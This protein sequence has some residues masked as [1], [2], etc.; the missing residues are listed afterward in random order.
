MSS[1]TDRIF[2]YLKL[3]ARILLIISSLLLL[4][5]ILLL[6]V[7]EEECFNV[8]SGVGDIM[9]P[10]IVASIYSVAYSLLVIL[11]SLLYYA[12]GRQG[13]WPLLKKEILLLVLTGILI[14]VFYFANRY[15]ISNYH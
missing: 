6:F 10:T 5:S 8:N 13:I 12:N 15:F 1:K 7:Y 4:L 14:A 11:S 3:A 2:S 9:W